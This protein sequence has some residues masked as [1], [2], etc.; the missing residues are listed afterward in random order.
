MPPK[1]VTKQQAVTNNLE[2]YEMCNSRSQTEG[3]VEC[4]RTPGQRPQT[5]ERGRSILKKE[6]VNTATGTIPWQPHTSDAI[7]SGVGSPLAKHPGNRTPQGNF[8][9]RMQLKE[10]YDS[11]VNLRPPSRKREHQTLLKPLVATPTQW[12]LQKTGRLQSVVTV[13]QKK[14]TPE[15]PQRD[16]ST[17]QDRSEDDVVAQQRPDG[18]FM[19]APYHL[20]TAPPEQAE[21]FLLYCTD[22]FNRDDFEDK[23]T[24]F[25]NV[26]EHRTAFTTH[27]CMA[28]AYTSR[29]PG[30]MAKNGYSPLSRRRCKR[31]CHDEAQLYLPH[32]PT[33]RNAKEKR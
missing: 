2:M 5:E 9:F 14:V 28:M 13:V 3:E 26:F 11:Y 6:T 10:T 1:L 4:H 29:S 17:H 33:R 23:L 24:D 21:E 8:K 20:I 25:G 22:R 31:W 19:S 7:P 16:K 30:S 12:P 18:T 15:Q 32:L 27:Y